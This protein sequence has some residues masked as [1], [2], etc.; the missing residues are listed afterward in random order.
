MK[1][2]NHLC[3]S[4]VTIPSWWPKL[5]S[6]WHTWLPLRSTILFILLA[7]VGLLE[8]G[9]TRMANSDYMI[10]GSSAAS[11]YVLPHIIPDNNSYQLISSIFSSGSVSQLCRTTRQS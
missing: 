4:E 2:K 10:A 6:D 9:S 1:P 3:I 7:L 5:P 11:S 8:S